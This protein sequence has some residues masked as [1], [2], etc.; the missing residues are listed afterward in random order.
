MTR[1]RRGGPPWMGGPWMSGHAIQGHGMGCC[2]G[3]SRWQ[4][5]VTIE[6]EIDGL[7]EIQRDLEEAA[8]DVAE[9]IRR[10]KE[11]ETADAGT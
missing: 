2:G 5:H 8:A 1:R 10:L 9:R 7:E 11:H 4:D 6:Q 3:T